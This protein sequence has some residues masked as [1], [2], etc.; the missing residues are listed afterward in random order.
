MAGWV[1]HKTWIDEQSVPPASIKLDG[2][3]MVHDLKF[4]AMIDMFLS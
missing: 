4:Q 3:S 1:Y 2:G